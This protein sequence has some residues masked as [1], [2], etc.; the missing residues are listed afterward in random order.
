MFVNNTCVACPTGTYQ[1]ETGQVVCKPC[2]E[3]T[4]TLYDGTQNV[5]HCLR[6]QTLSFT[7]V[8]S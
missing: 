7:Q 5:S 3:N 8:D 4:Y 6:K 1:D 2:P